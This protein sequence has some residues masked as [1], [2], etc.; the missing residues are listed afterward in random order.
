MKKKVPLSFIVGVL[1]IA[2]FEVFAQEQAEGPRYKDGDFWQFRATERNWF[3]SS[4]AALIGD[5]EVS[6]SEGKPKVFKL[7]G[8][9]KV[10]WP[11]DTGAELRRMLN[12][13][14][15]YEYL[16]FPLFMG[17]NWR[18]SYT[19]TLR[20]ARPQRYTRNFENRVTGIEEVSTPAG[21]FR[22][23][24]I[25]REAWSG[26]ARR[27]LTYYYSPLTRSIVKWSYYEENQ[28]S[29]CCEREIDLIKFGSAR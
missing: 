14:S 6:Y 26:Q 1:L 11:Y 12:I 24:K 8:G 25:E 9:G 20:G 3:A 27:W 10:E 16:R 19:T 23:F 15:S 5:F 13:K 29:R 28:G 17:Q 18:G 22:G 21:T 2:V 4:T 7:E